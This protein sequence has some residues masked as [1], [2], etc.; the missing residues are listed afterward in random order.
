MVRDQDQFKMLVMS[1]HLP[2]S[3]HMQRFFNIKQDDPGRINH[4]TNSTYKRMGIVK[5]KEMTKSSHHR[6]SCAVLLATHNGSEYLD[7][8]LA[9]IY[10]QIGVN[11]Q[12]FFLMM[13]PPI[14]Q[15]KWCLKREELI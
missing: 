8:Q 14:I 6:Y 3:K 12:I 9:S 1:R 4:I 5:N 11:V 10:S 2:S 15:D 13:D 7:V